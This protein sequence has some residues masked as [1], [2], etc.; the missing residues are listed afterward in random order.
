LNSAEAAAPLW[1]Q[2]LAETR[3]RRHYLSV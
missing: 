1:T 3:G 2:H